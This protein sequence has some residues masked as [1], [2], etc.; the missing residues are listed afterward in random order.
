MRLC[1]TFILMNSSDYKDRFVAEYWQLKIRTDNLE[2]MLVKYDA[3]TLDFKPTCPI[4]FLEHQFKIMSEYLRI[5]RIRAEMEHINI[6]EDGDKPR[7]VRSVLA[8][9]LNGTGEEV[10]ALND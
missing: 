6:N 10:E 2:N 7:S 9:V 4:Q 3:G 1:D 5:L 8:D